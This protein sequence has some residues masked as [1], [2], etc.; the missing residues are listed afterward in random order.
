M[1]FSGL[2]LLIASLWNADAC[3]DDKAEA[4][5]VNVHLSAA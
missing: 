5:R 4:R 2:P 3:L 1:Y